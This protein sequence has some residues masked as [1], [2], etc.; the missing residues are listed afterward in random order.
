MK[1]LRQRLGD[2]IEFQGVGGRAMT[3]EGLVSL[4]P[5][6]E[7]SIVGLAAVLRQV[8]KLLRLIG[9]DRGRGHRRIRRH[10]RHHRQSGFHPSR[11]PAGPRQRSVDPD[12]RLRFSDGVGL[13]A[14]PRTRATEQGM[15]VPPKPACARESARAK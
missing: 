11:C 15:S 12:R 5:I 8:P 9:A 13:A 2:A 14:R 4:F 1:V 7:V 3:R 10:S 6:E